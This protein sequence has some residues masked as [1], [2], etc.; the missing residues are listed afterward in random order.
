MVTPEETARAMV[1][2][3]RRELEAQAGAAA[4]ARAAATE[5]LR[6]ALRDG[7]A[8]RAWLVGSVVEGPFTADSDVDVV[9]EGVTLAAEGALREALFEAVQRQVDLLRY[10]ELGAAGQARVVREGSVVPEPRGAGQPTPRAHRGA[11]AE[12]PR[13]P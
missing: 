4:R 9:V 8:Q 7:V 10:E 5:V 2:R 6:G 12:G 3:A 1:E 13:G 11:A